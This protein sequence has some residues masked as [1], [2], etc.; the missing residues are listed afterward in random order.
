P[1]TFTASGTAGAPSAARSLVVAAP[2]TI[3][4][5]TGASA[6]TITVTANDEFGNPV[7]GV[8]VTLGATGTGNALAQPA[9][10][11]GPNGQVTGTLSSTKAETKTI[12][13]T[14]NGVTQVGATA[15]VSVTPAAAASIAVSTGDGQ[16][17]TA[18]TAV[19]VPPAVIV[20]DAFANPVAGV[21]VTFAAGTGGGSI[22]G[23]SQTTNASGVAAGTAWTLGPTAGSN[24]LTAASGSL[25]GSPVTFTATGTAGTA[26]RLAIATQPSGTVQSGIEFQQQPVIQ[27]QDASGNLVSQAGIVV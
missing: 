5:S 17:A 18:G 13:A 16:T 8:T 26:T 24:T 14:L 15:S 22:T 23:A 10:P 20:R 12:S 25:A 21:S 7:S 6:A 27:L 4:A 1:I 11:T 19:L 2:G 9:G 3:T